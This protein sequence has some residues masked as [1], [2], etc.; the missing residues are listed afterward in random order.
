MTSD[1]FLLDQLERTQ[2][3]QTRRRRESR[4]QRRRYYALASLFLIAFGVLAAP[5]LVSHSP[6]GKSVL[7]RTAAAYGFTAKA[8]A[9]RVGWVTPLRID[10]LT[11]VGDKAGSQF[12]I[13]QIDTELTVLDLLSSQNSELGSILV[14]GVDASCQVSEGDSSI[15]Q[16]LRYFLDQPAD[17]APATTGKVEVSD[18]T[19]TVRDEQTGET[20]RLSQASTQFDL[21]ADSIQSRFTGVLAEPRG[22]QG[23]L[24]GAIE[25]GFAAS[26]KRTPGS[27]PATPWNVDLTCDSLP[28]SVVSLVRRRMSAYAEQIPA[29]WVGDATGNLQV[30]GR[31]NGSIDAVVHQFQI[32]NL[33]ATDLQQD[34]RRWSN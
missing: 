26:D 4:N 20:W 19:L 17:D 15:E 28:L 10:G 30:R 24:Q 7:V 2:Q 5:S 3:D 16:D 31:S 25:Y 13:Q 8:E 18:I 27:Q 29:Q 34:A 1:D 6:I 23:S 32:R 21:L 22:S 14:R 33:E 11:V 9:L 12:R